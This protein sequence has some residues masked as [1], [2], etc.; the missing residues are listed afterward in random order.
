MINYMKNL[1]GYL[2][3]LPNER[4]KQTNA[5]CDTLDP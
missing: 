2:F 5:V 3:V 1:E 4:Y